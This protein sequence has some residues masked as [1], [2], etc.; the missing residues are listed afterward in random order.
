MTAPKVCPS[1][2]LPLCLSFAVATR[3]EDHGAGRSYVTFPD[4]PAIAKSGI[5][6]VPLAMRPGVG[7]VWRQSFGAG[8]CNYTRTRTPSEGRDHRHQRGRRR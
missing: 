1:L 3:S 6:I 2:G 8:T 5:A 4:Q 7:C